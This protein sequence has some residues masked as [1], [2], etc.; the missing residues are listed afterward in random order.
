MVLF[1]FVIQLSA[2]EES[3]EIV[4]GQHQYIKIHNIDSKINIAI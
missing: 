1:I 4:E 2:N 3:V